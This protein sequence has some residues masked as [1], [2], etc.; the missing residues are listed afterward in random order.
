MRITLKDEFHWIVLGQVEAVTN[1]DTGQPGWQDTLGR[2]MEPC[3]ALLL[4]CWGH[5]IWML[6]RASLSKTARVLFKCHV[7]KL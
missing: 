3:S 7:P 1:L 2:H 6:L 4:V 5:L